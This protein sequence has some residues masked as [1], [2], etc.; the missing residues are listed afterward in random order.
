[1]DQDLAHDL[2]LLRTLMARELE[3]INHYRALAERA[4]AGEARELLLHVLEEEKHHVAQALGMM[5]SLDPDQ[6][7]LLDAGTA[8]GHR[9]GELPPRGARP[10]E[11]A[12]PSPPEPAARESRAAGLTVGS[13][14]GVPQLPSK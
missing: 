7:E 14:R 3:T 5:A 11:D 8:P 9:P 2:A 12:A 10:A 4:D 1:M 13:L 6:A